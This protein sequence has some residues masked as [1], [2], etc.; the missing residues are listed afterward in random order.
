MKFV[1]SLTQ[2]PLSA[3]LRCA[4]KLPDAES[5]LASLA[6]RLAD[7]GSNWLT[8]HA[9]PR[10]DGHKGTADWALVGRIRNQ[11]SI[12]VV[13]N[14][15]IQTADDAVAVIQDHGVDGAMIGRALAARPWIFWQIADK[16]G[17]KS[18]PVG[19]PG[20]R[21]PC[22][23]EQESREYFRAALM[24]LELLQR[25]Y[26]TDE[27]VLKRFRFFVQTGSPWFTY[28]HSLWAMTTKHQTV[29][30]LR[31]ALVR[32]AERATHPI[33]GRVEFR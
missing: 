9:R 32:Y 14:G 20:E 8:I 19:R 16:L 4:D 27:L 7:A 28:G 2:M 29:D 30:A 12:P 1:R 13:A 6:G 17:L 24:F 11:L 33:A 3:K 23:P 22:A 18:A 21:A 26:P 31:D 5:R 15:D 25:D 10:Q